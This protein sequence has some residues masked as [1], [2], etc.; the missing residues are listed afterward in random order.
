MLKRIEE[1]KRTAAQASRAAAQPL[2]ERL[3]A[4]EAKLDRLLDAHLEGV[5]SRE[6]YAGRKEKLLLEKSALSA[7]LA[8]VER[9]GN[10]WLEPLE[11]F[12]RAADQAHSVASAENLEA[13]KE[14]TTRIGSNLRLAGRTVQLSYENPWRLVAARGRNDN[15]WRVRDSMRLTPDSLRIC[16]MPSCETLQNAVGPVPLRPT[17]KTTRLKHPRHDRHP[18]HPGVSR[19]AGL[20]AQ[21]FQNVSKHLRGPEDLD[22]KE[23]TLGVEFECDPRRDLDR[24]GLLP[25]PGEVQD[26]L[27]LVIQDL[28]AH[29]GTHL[30]PARRRAFSLSRKGWNVIS[31]TPS[32]SSSYTT[33]TSRSRPVTRRRS[34]AIR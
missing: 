24:F 26:I 12:V 25:F 14:W 13:L 7:R 22:P 2:K 1:W 23:T 9:Q 21:R 11:R 33:I 18:L 4:L 20:G 19:H 6:E 28:E 16:G 27:G 32:G 34:A 17:P 30:P 10:H 29:R 15:W 5:I 8:E 3:A 31:T